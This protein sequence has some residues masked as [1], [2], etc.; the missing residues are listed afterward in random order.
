MSIFSVDDN[1]DKMGVV[2]SIVQMRNSAR[3]EGGAHVQ[4]V[5]SRGTW[6][7]AQLV[8]GGKYAPSARGAGVS[9]VEH[10][11]LREDGRAGGR[12]R[13]GPRF[14]ARFYDTTVWWR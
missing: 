3:G 1:S 8:E 14:A 12:G 5:V 13:R 6:H 10:D 7:G 4:T 9:F 2:S 11:A